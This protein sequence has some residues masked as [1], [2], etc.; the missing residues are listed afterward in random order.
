MRA[1]VLHKLN[2]RFLL[3]PKLEVAVHAAAYEEVCGRGL[4]ER[5]TTFWCV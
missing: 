4:R 2:P 3:L 1:V 5:E